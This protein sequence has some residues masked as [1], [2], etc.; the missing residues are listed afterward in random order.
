MKINKAFIGR[1]FIGTLLIM[2]I[3]SFAISQDMVRAKIGIELISGN[4]SKR[5]KAIDRIKPGKNFR[6]YIIPE[7]DSHVYVIH[8]DHNKVTLLNHSVVSKGST[9][10]LPSADNS[11]QIDGLS[12]KESF[13][14]ICSKDK[15]LNVQ[16]VLSSKNVPHSKW[17]K[18]EKS[19]LEESRIDLS[20]ISEKPYA[21][22]GNV[23]GAT[24]KSKGRPVWSPE[25]IPLYSGKSFLVKRFR[26]N[27][28]R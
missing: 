24:G 3:T 20:E 9:L 23:R 13:T 26:F 18:L 12:K 21:M 16:N 4:S 2:G 6:I 10:V 7:K 17:V 28:I 25:K 19:L 5:A 22:A 11:F 14:I 1:V 15:L 8:T 27:V